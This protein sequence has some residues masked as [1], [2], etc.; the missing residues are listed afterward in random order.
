MFRGLKFVAIALAILSAAE[1]AFAQF[2]PN[3]RT[4]IPYLRRQVPPVIN[5]DFPLLRLAITPSQAAAI[6]KAQVPGSKVVKVNLRGDIYN[7]RL[8]TATSVVL[9]RVS[10]R[11][12][13][14]M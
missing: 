12:G 8:R 9:I 2:Q 7:V 11:D 3:V 10:G 4:T 1:P 5:P 14:I 13:S 6:A